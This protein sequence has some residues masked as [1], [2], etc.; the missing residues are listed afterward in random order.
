ML[1]A[2]VFVFVCAGAAHAQTFPIPANLGDSATLARTM[3]A[4]AE[5]VIAQYKDGDRARML[6]NL[7]RLQIVAGRYDDATR[8]LTELRAIRSRGATVK[9]DARAADV[10]YEVWARAMAAKAKRGVL[11]DRAF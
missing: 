3:P 7:F 9:P 4:L 11:F 5:R 10:Q 1:R 6:D 8:S 2:L